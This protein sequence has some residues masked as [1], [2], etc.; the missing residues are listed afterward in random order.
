MKYEFIRENTGRYPMGV[1]FEV[2]GLKS[3]GYYDWLGRPPSERAKRDAILKEQVSSLHKRARG[4]YGYR[5]VKSHLQDDGF[6]CGRDRAL[7]LMRELGLEGIQKKS[8]KAQCT[9]SNHN[10][11]YSPNLLARMGKPTGCD[12]AWVADTTYLK[13]DAGWCYLATVMDLYSRRILGW[14]VSSHNDSSL[15]C[16]ALEAAVST[17]GGQ[18]P[19]G[20]C[21]HSDRGSTYACLQYTRLLQKYQM[22]PSMSRKGNCYDNAAMESFYGK[23]KL[24]SVRGHQFAGEGEARANAFEYIEVFYNRFRKHSSLGYKNPVQFEAMASENETGNQPL[25]PACITNN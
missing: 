24:S 2:L 3:S 9:D 21:H 7:R 13:T 19:A 10:F 4:R 22:T 20:I 15:V 17:R 14:S 23:Y 18:M 25:Q 6:A 8:F 1:M 16:R 12:Q 11:G 5:P